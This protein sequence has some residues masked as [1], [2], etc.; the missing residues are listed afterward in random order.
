M[1]SKTTCKCT[2]CPV[3]GNFTNSVVCSICNV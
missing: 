3:C 2:Y 1:S